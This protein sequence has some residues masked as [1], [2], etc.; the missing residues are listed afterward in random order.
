MRVAPSGEGG[1]RTALAGMRTCARPLGAA[2]LLVLAVGPARGASAAGPLRPVECGECA[3][4]SHLNSPCT[5][6]EV[7]KHTHRCCQMQRASL[8]GLAQY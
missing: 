8:V 7:A 1:L 5:A 6:N 4:G 2:L 3:A